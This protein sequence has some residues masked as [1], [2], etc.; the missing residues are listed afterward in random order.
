[1]GCRR[2]PGVGKS[3]RAFARPRLPAR[4]C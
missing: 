1:V 2:P 4:H 3:R